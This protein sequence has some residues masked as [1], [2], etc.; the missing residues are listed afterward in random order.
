[1]E[2]CVFATLFIF[3]TIIGSFLNVVVDRTDTKESPFKGRS[4]CPYC[5]KTLTWWEMVPVL[6]YFYLKGRCSSC[7]HKLSL[8][9]PLVEFFTGLFFALAGWRFLRLPLINLHLFTALNLETMLLIIN[10]IFW[11]YWIFVFIAISVYDLKKYLIL[12]EVLF[13]AMMLSFIWRI[14]LG[15][16][17]KAHDFIF[18]P[19]ITHVLGSQSYVFG[20][21]PYFLSLVLGIVI[22]AG[23]ISLLAYFTKERAMGWGDAFVALFIGLILG[24]PESLMALIIAFLSGGAI[25]L[26][27]MLFKKK[28][29]KSYLPFAPFLTLGALSILLFGD[30]IM[31]G[32]LSI[33]LI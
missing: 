7:H 18:L 10:F 2:I 17:L 15:I 33:L 31:K 13:P 3:G 32:Y 27:L 29:I 19:Q 4:L 30:I 26:V 25:S 5:H 24:W 16:L 28:T 8:Q 20:N 22:S 21:Y 14:V 6:N 12:S 1:M 9:Y 23:L 11:L